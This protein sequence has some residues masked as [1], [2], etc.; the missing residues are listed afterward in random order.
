MSRRHRTEPRGSVLKRLCAALLAP[1]LAPHHAPHLPPVPFAL[2]QPRPRPHPRPRPRIA[3]SLAAH[4]SATRSNLQCNVPTQRPAECSVTLHSSPAS[5]L[6]PRSKTRLA[7]CCPPLHRPPPAAAT[8]ARRTATPETAHIPIFA[9]TAAN[10]PLRQ[11]RRRPLHCTPNVALARS[12]ANR[13]NTTALT[14]PSGLQHASN[15]V[16]TAEQWRV[17]DA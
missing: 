12:P 5:T 16:F 3:A 14:L 7:P 6:V 4:P 9:P 13:N 8:T 10:T 15:H 17:C 1:R 2:S 11:P